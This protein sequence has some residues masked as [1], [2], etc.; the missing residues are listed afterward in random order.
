MEVNFRPE[1]EAELLEAQAWYEERFPG[2]GLEFART[3]DVAVTQALRNP[4][5][6]SR[7]EEEFRHVVLR[8]FPYSIV[9]LPSAHELLIVSC[10]HHRREPGSWQDRDRA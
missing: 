5:A 8:R 6:Y 1:A 2:L 10:F 4:L 9:Y 7:I 3:V